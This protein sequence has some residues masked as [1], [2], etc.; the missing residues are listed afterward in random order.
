MSPSLRIAIFPTAS[1]LVGAPFFVGA[2]MLVAGLGVV[3]MLVGCSS[4]S[5]SD[6]RRISVADFAHPPADLAD[7]RGDDVVEMSPEILA[8]PSVEVEGTERIRNGQVTESV[9]AEVSERLADGSTAIDAVTPPVV[10]TRIKV[11]GN[12]PVDALVGQINGRPIFADTFFE[13]HADRLIAMA[14]MPDRVVGREQF[15]RTV[16]AVFKETVD[17]ELIV[18]EAESQ[19]SDE[20]QQGLFAWLRGIQEETIA[21][22]GGSRAAAEAS[23]ESERTQSLDEFMQERR[24]VALAGRLLNQRIK[25][26][27]IVAWREV[28]QAYDRDRNIY[29]PP[30]QV[31][32][33][34]IR[35]DT[36][37][38]AEKIERMKAL[39][40]EGRTFSDIIKEFAIVDGGLW[41]SSDLPADGIDGLPLSDAV[42]A[43]IKGLAVDKVSE[44]LQQRDFTSWFTV[45]AIERPNARSVYDRELQLAISNQLRS[46]RETIERQR[47]LSTLR[48]RWVTD[49]IGEMEDRLIAFALD[50]YW[51]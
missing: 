30:Q 22:R 36:L 18:A 25:P 5:P 19:L 7:G 28:L 2:P 35:F 12:W 4:N 37:A 46:V 38:D 45:I 44:P 13:P 16:K 29:N 50:R 17:S 15:I 24:D 51:R 21:E 43:R 3:S 1:I 10:A 27:A 9:R 49:D 48:S 8:K 42:K 11:G 47:Y 34:R 6:V 14:A 20:Q 26:R 39:V 33:G 31:K 40:A 41:Q 23:L 32:I